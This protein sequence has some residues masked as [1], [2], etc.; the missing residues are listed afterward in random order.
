M[1]VYFSTPNFFPVIF[2][3]WMLFTIVVI[4]DGFVFISKNLA[5]GS[6]ITTEN[7]ISSR[8]NSLTAG[9][10]TYSQS[11]QFSSSHLCRERWQKLYMYLMRAF[12]A[13]I[14]SVRL[15]QRF[16]QKRSFSIRKRRCTMELWLRC[17]Y[18]FFIRFRFI[19][20]TFGWTNS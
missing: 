14:P 5:C 9:D 15:R 2:V 19:T 6:G 10:F 4:F 16:N 12:Y 8:L 3:I 18:V 20:V 17:R 11:T 13:F 7:S 1:H